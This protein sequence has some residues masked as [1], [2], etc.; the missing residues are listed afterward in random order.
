MLPADCLSVF[1]HF[2]G[3]ALKELK[4]MQNIL[5]E[6]YKQIYIYIYILLYIVIQKYSYFR[7]TI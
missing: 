7:E 5:R 3:L 2:V 6:K 4:D 1:D